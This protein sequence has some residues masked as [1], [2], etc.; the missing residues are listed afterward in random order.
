MTDKELNRSSRGIAY[1]ASHLMHSWG[2]F[3]RQQIGIWLQQTHHDHL[4]IMIITSAALLQIY[5]TLKSRNLTVQSAQ[6][7][8]IMLL[9][10]M[11]YLKNIILWSKS[12]ILLVS[13]RKLRDRKDKNERRKYA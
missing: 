11:V 1:T 12:Q 8:D 13:S 5:E 2:H 4:C 7:D 6:M 3:I 10:R 9:K